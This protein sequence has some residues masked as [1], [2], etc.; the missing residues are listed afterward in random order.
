MAVLDHGQVTTVPDPRPRV[1]VAA[2]LVV[3]ALLVVYV[4]WGSTYLAIRVTVRE[5][6]PFLGMG[7]RYVAAGLLLGLVVGFRIGFR[8]LLVT[9]REFLGCAFVGLMLPVLGNGVVALG[10]SKGTP[11]GVAALLVALTPLMITVFRAASGDRP[12]GLTVAGVGLGFVGVAYLVLAGNSNPTDSLPLIPSLIVLF[13]SICWAF[14]S[15][16]QPHLRLPRNAF[17][18]TVYEM[19]T[20]GVML[21]VFGLLRGEQLHVADYHATTWLAWSYLVVFG[22]MLGFTAYVW[23]L[24]NAPISL[25]A[26]YAYVNPIVAVVLGA[27]ILS[28]PVTSAVLIGGGIIIAGVVIVISAERPHHA[29]VKAKAGIT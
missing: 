6:P 11:S 22:S 4:V 27:L 26:T 5:A 19:W 16:A 3:A 15:W 8:K 24:A 14:G 18:L 20:G 1:P 23:L 13:A 7:T 2:G 12:R 25:V 9:R 17:V 10:E 21:I 28:E 29:G